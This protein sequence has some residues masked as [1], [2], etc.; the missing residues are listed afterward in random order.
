MSIQVGYRQNIKHL[1]KKPDLKNNIYELSTVSISR[2]YPDAP[3]TSD[4]KVALQRSPRYCFNVSTKAKEDTTAYRHCY[5]FD[6]KDEAIAEHT[7]LRLRW[8][9]QLTAPILKKLEHS[10]Q[11]SIQD[12]M[13]LDSIINRI[14]RLC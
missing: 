10:A 3:K 12:Q 8:Y 1:N 4:P 6:N 2:Y 9:D 5:Y 7:K 11:L 14:E 13:R